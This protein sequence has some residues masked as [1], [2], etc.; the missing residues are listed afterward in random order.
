[1]EIPPK[2]ILALPVDILQQILYHALFTGAAAE[3]F[4]IDTG[5]RNRVLFKLTPF[6]YRYP[7]RCPLATK[8]GLLF[9]CR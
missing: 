4:A 9:S 2:N 8:P 5:V 6:A 7:N 1:M 3:S